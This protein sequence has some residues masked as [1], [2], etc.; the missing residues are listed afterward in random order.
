MKTF[1]LTS[2][3]FDTLRNTGRVDADTAWILDGNQFGYSP[4]GEGMFWYDSMAELLENH[5]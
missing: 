5:S 3:H 4:D 1:Q 2:S